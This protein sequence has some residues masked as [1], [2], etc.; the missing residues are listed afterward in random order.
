MT[1]RLRTFNR[2]RK[3]KAFLA[4][5]HA[6]VVKRWRLALAPGLSVEWMKSAVQ[7]VWRREFEQIAAAHGISPDQ[8]AWVKPRLSSY[9]DPVRDGAPPFLAPVPFS[10]ATFE[11]FL[12]EA[13]K[14]SYA[15]GGTLNF[16]PTKACFPI[17]ESGPELVGDDH[18]PVRNRSVSSIT[19]KEL[20]IVG[21]KRQRSPR[22]G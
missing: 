16:K 14:G 3:R 9:I 10:T 8:I 12:S 13:T 17:G 18:Y 11:K 22:P 1:H 4:A 7:D 19:T 6:R 5:E 20:V 15:S 2:R 21:P